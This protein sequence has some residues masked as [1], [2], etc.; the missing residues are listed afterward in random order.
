MLFYLAAII[1]SFWPL[2]LL[3]LPLLLLLEWSCLLLVVFDSLITQHVT[4]EL[5]QSFIYIYNIVV[6]MYCIMM[7]SFI[8]HCSSCIACRF[9]NPRL[10]DD[11]TCHQP[12]TNLW[13]DFTLFNRCLTY[14]FIFLVLVL[15][16][17]LVLSRF[18][19][20]LGLMLLPSDLKLS[21][22]TLHLQIC[23]MRSY[24]CTQI[25]HSVNLMN[26]LFIAHA[27]AILR[28]NKYYY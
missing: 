6:K 5:S 12:E 3:L 25:V 26:P 16:L 17:A 14:L 10:S 2:L 22:K 24:T 19:S 23:T 18:V 8:V 20:F 15:V 9:A 7:H 4:T 21:A 28:G 1:S 27:P 11:V 13:P